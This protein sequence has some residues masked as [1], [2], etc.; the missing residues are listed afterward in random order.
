M[1]K[2]I[3]M[4][5]IIIGLVLLYSYKLL[6]VPPGLT[7]DEASFGYNAALL[8]Q[9]GKDERGLPHPIFVLSVSG[10]DWRQPMTQYYLATLFKIFGPSVFLLRFSSVIIAAI[11]VLGVYFL[12]SSLLGISGG[13]T[14]AAITALAPIVTIQA[15]LGLDNIMPVPFVILWLFS[16][17]RYQKSRS[18]TSLAIC[19]LALG[20]SFYSYKGMRAITPIWIILTVGWLFWDWRQKKS[21]SID[22]FLFVTVLSPFFLVIPHL[23]KNYAGAI[24]G[25]SSP[26]FGTVYDFFVPYLSSFDPSYLFI[27]GDI[28]QYHSTG[29]HGMLLLAS[30]PLIITG[31]YAAAKSKNNFL[32]FVLVSLLA[33]PLLYGAV[34]SDHRFSRLLALIPLYSVLGGL[35]FDWLWQQKSRYQK[36][37]SLLI[38]FLM[39]LNYVDFANYYWHDYPPIIRNLLGDM[40]YYPSLATFKSETDQN[41]LEPVIHQGVAAGGGESLKF[42]EVVYFGRLLRTIPDDSSPSDGELL[43][44]VRKE[45]PCTQKVG[46]TISNY[47]IFRLAKDCI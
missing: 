18:L 33:G 23:E 25:N 45:V 1:K 42:F 36:T 26:G 12:A 22:L 13:I 34:G 40:S 3:V 46:H 38:L 8:S 19:A 43:L 10:K 4:V 24:L 39:L 30:L 31:I 17:Y 9:T 28:T 7:V 27:R 44:T 5:F 37:I 11:C 29:R 21:R 41:K 20:F 6:E 35:G 16:L 14:A 15:H 32:K 2:L 47:F